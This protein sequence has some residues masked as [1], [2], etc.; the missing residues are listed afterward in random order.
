MNPRYGK[1]KKIDADSGLI[2]AKLKRAQDHY[3]AASALEVLEESSNA[4]VSLYVNAAITA[5]DA[6]C[7]A[8]L[9][10]FPQG[11]DHSEAVRLGRVS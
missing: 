9:G 1:S 10:Y 11:G 6:L 5:S 2:H 8:A 3:A 7:G 4:I